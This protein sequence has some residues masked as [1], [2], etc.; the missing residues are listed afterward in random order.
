MSYASAYVTSIC[1]YA[2]DNSPIDR[3]I[4]HNNN[5]NNN[6]NNRVTN[7]IHYTHNGLICFCQH[8]Y[9]PTFEQCLWDR[10]CSPLGLAIFVAVE[11]TFPVGKLINCNFH[12]PTGCT[13]Y[14][15]SRSLYFKFYSLRLLTKRPI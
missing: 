7:S 10:V 9:I 6:N 3:Y 2:I 4:S 1:V 12:F 14:K 5:N 8:N 13:F 15:R 11:G